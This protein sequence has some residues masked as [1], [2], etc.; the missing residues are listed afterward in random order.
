[1]KFSNLEVS[2]DGEE[3]RYGRGGVCGELVFRS[4][5]SMGFF[6]RNRW[7]KVGEVDFFLF[8][9][10]FIDYRFCNNCFFIFKI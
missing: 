1:M 4:V 7:S 6:K 9:L 10:F 3:D 8:E 2:R 5:Y